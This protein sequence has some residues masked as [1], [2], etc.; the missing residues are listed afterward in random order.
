MSN[1]SGNLDPLQ[2]RLRNFAKYIYRA[3]LIHTIFSLSN[4]EY[5]RI[6][7]KI[8]STHIK[9]DKLISWYSAWDVYS[10]V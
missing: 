10:F 5:I 1:V 6:V 4:V 2:M 9:I 7:L 8:L 3:I